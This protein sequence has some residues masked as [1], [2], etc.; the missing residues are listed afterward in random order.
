[1]LRG[2]S[3]R[4]GYAAK[5][6][7]HFSSGDITLA[8]LIARILTER[9]DLTEKLLLLGGVAHSAQSEMLRSALQRAPTAHSLSLRYRD[10]ASDLQGSVRR[11][12][13]TLDLPPPAR[14]VVEKEMNSYSKNPSWKFDFQRAASHNASIGLRHMDLLARVESWLSENLGLDHELR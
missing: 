13:E 6:A 11:A 7:L 9:H 10:L 14:S 1:M 5:A 2:G 12:A 3:E 4:L 8:E